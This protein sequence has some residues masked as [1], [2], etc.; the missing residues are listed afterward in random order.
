M[1][2]RDGL[3]S[4]QA[5]RWRAFQYPGLMPVKKNPFTLETF[6]VTDRID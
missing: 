5:W 4:A 3:V 1:G 6:Y 2:D